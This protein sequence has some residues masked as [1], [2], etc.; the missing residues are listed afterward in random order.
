MQPPRDRRHVLLITVLDERGLID[1][2]ASYATT[3]LD[4]VPSSRLDEGDIYILLRKLKK[5]QEDIRLNHKLIAKIQSGLVSD[6]V[7][8]NIT[9]IGDISRSPFIAS[10]QVM[11][12]ETSN[13]LNH[14]QS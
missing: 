3:E 7:G 2:L 4:R 6:Q 1:K 8:R 10:T 9:V 14:D 5:M 13:A 11:D 12:L